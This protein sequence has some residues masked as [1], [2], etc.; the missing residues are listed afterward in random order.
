MVTV[1]LLIC[2]ALG[3]VGTAHAAGSTCTP[4]APYASIDN[5]WAWAAWG[6]WGLPGQQLSYLINVTDY[7]VGCGSSSFVI[8]MS[9]PNGF[10]V[11]LPTN[12]IT[13]K[14]S[15]SG[16]L[17]AHVTSPSTIAN[18]DYPL[19]LTVQRTGTPGSGAS[20][21]SYYKVYS[22]DTVA[23]TLF[24]ASLSDGLTLSGRSFNVGVTSSDDHAVNRIELYID[25]V[26]R[27]TTACDDI[28]WSCQLDYTWS[29]RGVSGQH[30]ATFKSYDW[31]GN[32]GIQTATFTVT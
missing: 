5:N 16:T 2:Y 27:S 7:D 23:P 19:T 12:T 1:L 9:A 8:S 21:T 18:G 25:D 17:S 28:A 14:S 29:L 20:L 15:S 32:V 11:S 24:W 4:K 3:V 30:T 26:Y 10:S 22:S 6:S 31:M 13:L